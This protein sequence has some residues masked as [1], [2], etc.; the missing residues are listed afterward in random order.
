MPL[1]DV[2][3]DHAVLFHMWRPLKKA[4]ELVKKRI[5]SEVAPPPAQIG[6]NAPPS[7]GKVKNS[8]Q[9]LVLLGIEPTT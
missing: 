4:A 3:S 6:E 5:I 8:L 9:K 2:G 1:P 7:W